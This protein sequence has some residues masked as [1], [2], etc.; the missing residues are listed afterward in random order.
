MVVCIINQYT[1]YEHYIPNHIRKEE[2]GED[3]D[4]KFRHLINGFDQEKY[5]LTLNS[6]I[7]WK[8]IPFCFL[9]QK[10]KK[11]IQNIGQ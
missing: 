3:E 2:D 4:I 7:T 9:K 10:K 8:E 1:K 5:E 6:Q 11:E